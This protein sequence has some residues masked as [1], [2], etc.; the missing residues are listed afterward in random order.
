MS[1]WQHRQDPR[2]CSSH[3]APRQPQSRHN[4]GR[5]RPHV[6]CACMC[7][8]AAV[9]CDDLGVVVEAAH[10][11]VPAHLA[12]STSLGE[13]ARRHVS[14]RLRFSCGSP[15][16][17]EGS[18]A[19]S[20]RS[21]SAA[22]RTVQRPSRQEVWRGPSQRRRSSRQPWE[23]RFEWL[24]IP[25]AANMEGDRA[26]LVFVRV[27]VRPRSPSLPRRLLFSLLPGLTSIQRRFGGGAFAVRR[28]ASGWTSSTESHGISWPL[29]Q[30]ALDQRASLPLLCSLV[31]VPVL[32]CIA[33]V[34]SEG[35]SVG[36]ALSTVVGPCSVSCLR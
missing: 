31:A 20:G 17:P 21:A 22:G 25:N 33:F 23:G 30:C 32:E 8:L 36:V 26:A 28:N 1:R 24:H 19:F 29:K 35:V 18:T 15:L 10:G 7:K 13:H 27:A 2:R 14:S 4:L 16:L 5:L 9:Q 6:H 12:Q 3:V 11:N 34:L